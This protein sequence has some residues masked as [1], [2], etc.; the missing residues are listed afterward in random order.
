[1]DPVLRLLQT[2]EQTRGDTRTQAA[3]T[4]EFLLMSRPEAERNVADAIVPARAALVR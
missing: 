4:A 2:L 1:M 3:L